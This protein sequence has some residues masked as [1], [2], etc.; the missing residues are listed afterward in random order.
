MAPS[1]LALAV[2]FGSEGRAAGG[3]EAEEGVVL[4]PEVI[5]SPVLGEEDRGREG[6]RV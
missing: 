1:H 4:M 6:F 5:S 2:V 3:L